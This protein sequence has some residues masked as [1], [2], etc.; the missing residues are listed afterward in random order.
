MSV[1]VGTRA[2]T[3][4][5]GTGVSWAEQVVQRRLAETFPCTPVP[6]EVGWV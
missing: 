6:S 5:P 2:P 4:A 3:W 1:G